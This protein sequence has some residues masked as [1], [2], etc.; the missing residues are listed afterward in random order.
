MTNWREVRDAMAD[1]FDEE[2]SM[3]IDGYAETFSFKE[4]W[5]AAIE[6]DP[7]VKALKTASDEVDSMVTLI[8]K[9]NGKNTNLLFDLDDAHKNLSKA[10]SL[11]EEK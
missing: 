3:T 5:S 1:R 9:S 11:W 2:Q 7:R 8:K 6:H 4:G 10:L